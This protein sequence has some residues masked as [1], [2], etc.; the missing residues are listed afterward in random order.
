[1]T[2]EYS[3]DSAA[4]FN[5]SIVPHPDQ[6]NLADGA[7]RFLM[8]LRATGEGH[9]SSIV[10]RTGVITPDLQ[11]QVDPLPTKL[12]RARVHPDRFYEKNLF[13][14]KLSEMG[15]ARHTRRSP[16]RAP[17]RPIHPPAAH[18]GSRTSPRRD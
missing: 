2:M 17:T 16:P 5:P 8:S 3:I 15:L 1:M 9:V 13:R 12:H 18:A 11:V 7:V 4:L 14:W 6:S 10:F